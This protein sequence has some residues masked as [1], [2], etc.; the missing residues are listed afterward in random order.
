MHSIHTTYTQHNIYRNIHA[1]GLNLCM[2][3]TGALCTSVDKMVWNAE[4][5][6]KRGRD[7]IDITT[8]ILLDVDNATTLNR[9]YGT[10]VLAYAGPSNSNVQMLL[11]QANIELDNNSF[12]IEMGECF[13]LL[14]LFK[15]MEFLLLTTVVVLY[16]A[17]I[18]RVCH[19]NRDVVGHYT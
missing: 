15:W 8:T 16:F 1:N 7:I 13:S 4:R 19:R 12:Q 17:R 18:H 3:F 9:N 2:C 5:R 10:S 14:F 6:G 11:S